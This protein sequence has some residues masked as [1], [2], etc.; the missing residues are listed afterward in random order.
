MAI[1]KVISKIYIGTLHGTYSK[2]QE[3]TVSL[4]K[5]FNFALLDFDFFKMLSIFR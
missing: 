2:T 5:G 3:N 4:Y 1:T